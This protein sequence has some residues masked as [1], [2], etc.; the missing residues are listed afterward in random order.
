MR[1]QTTFLT[2]LAGRASYGTMEGKI[3]LNGKEDN[4]A[5]YPKL[6]GFV[7]QEDVMHR[8]LTVEEVRCERYLIS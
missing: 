1:D 6:V 5:R 7:P 8:N 4:L 3:Y 2:T